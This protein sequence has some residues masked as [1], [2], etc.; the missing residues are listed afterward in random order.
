ML[1]CGALFA[2]E[3]ELLSF[4]AV[5]PEGAI[6]KGSLEVYVHPIARHFL[7]DVG[8][9]GDWVQLED[10]SKWIVAHEARY[11]AKLWWPNDLVYI[12]QAPGGGSFGYWILNETR[13][14]YVRVGLLQK[15]YTYGAYTKH[16]EGIDFYADAVFLC[17]GSLWSMSPWDHY[18]LTHW[19][20]NDAA[21]IGLNSNADNYAYPFILINTSSPYCD[22][23]ACGLCN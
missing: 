21:V 15:P 17:D 3:G 12:T 11:E 7:Y 16:I 1:A 22:W 2:N 5:A 19:Y 4:R 18:K 23:A 8:V 14:V 13:G 20:G 9:L 10:G 6:A